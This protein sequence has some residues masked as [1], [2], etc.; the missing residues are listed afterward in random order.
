MRR[1]LDALVAAAVAAIAL[2][3]AWD[4]LRADPAAESAAAPDPL[5]AAA[6]A[7]LR[8]LGASGQILFSDGECVR[9]RLLLPDLELRTIPLI[10]GCSVFGHRGSLGVVDGEVGWYAYPGGV[11]MLL[12]RG[13]LAREVGAA[14]ARVV[15]AAWLAN[16][17]YAALVERP[18]REARL[19]ALFER[20]RLTR[21]V[22][23]L[24]RGYDELRSSPQ[25]GWFAALDGAGGRL[26]LYDARGVAA[27]LPPHLERPHAIAWSRDDRLA[28]VADAVGI[29]FFAPGV[30]GAPFVRLALP[31]VD[32]AWR[33]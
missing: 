17:R 11:T 18:G 32:L 26:E 1:P 24:G 25:G 23:E 19:L 10:V 29:G 6:S 5:P 2:A 15:A 14:G 31:A 12:T 7:E 3:A 21:V 33:R 22:G 20:D 8:G 27:P 9:N 4:A 28:A 16:T 30:D 13:E